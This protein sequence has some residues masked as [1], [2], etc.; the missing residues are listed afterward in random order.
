MLPDSENRGRRVRAI[1]CLCALPLS[2]RVAENQLSAAAYTPY[3]LLCRFSPSLSLYSIVLVPTPFRTCQVHAV[4]P[5]AITTHRFMRHKKKTPPLDSENR[6]IPSTRTLVTL[7]CSPRART[8]HAR[9]FST[10]LVL[11]YDAPNFS[12]SRGPPSPPRLLGIWI[13]ARTCAR[14]ASCTTPFHW[15]ARTACPR[16]PNHQP[17]YFP[18]LPVLSRIG[19]RKVSPRR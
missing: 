4:S 9:N 17:G 7:P 11:T 5:D 10:N 18:L 3:D 19:R 13:P 6:R 14:T 12:F 2:P 1:S 16:H 8:L 15:R